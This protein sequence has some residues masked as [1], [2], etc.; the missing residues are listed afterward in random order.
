MRHGLIISIVLS[1]VISWAI[2]PV[3][4]H[5]LPQELKPDE[6]ISYK[7]YP[8][9]CED[10]D[11]IAELSGTEVH[12]TGRYTPVHVMKRMKASQEGSTPSTVQIVSPH[13]PSIM[14]GIYYDETGQRPEKE[15]AMFT[16]KDVVVSGLLH[17]NTPEQHGPDGIV[18]QTMI[19]PYLSDFSIRLQ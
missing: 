1:C 15:I 6:C 4:C 2:T 14:L 17:A 12:F 19:G 13:G 3:P 11:E 10:Y 5:E 8:A 9:C 16:G 7:A 18:L